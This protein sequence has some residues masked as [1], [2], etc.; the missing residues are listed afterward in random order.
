M[1]LDNGQ[2]TDMARIEKEAKERGKNLDTTGRS[3]T[4]IYGHEIP[5]TQSIIALGLLVS[6]K[7]S[8]ARVGFGF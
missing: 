7:V 1:F 2:Q 8:V 6:W 5:P 4:F 3:S